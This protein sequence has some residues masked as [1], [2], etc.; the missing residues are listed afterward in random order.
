MCA[1]TYI[2]EHA[3]FIDLALNVD[4]LYVFMSVWNFTCGGN[5]LLSIS[6]HIYM[7]A[8]KRD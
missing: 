2:H 5:R 1:C 6:I 3:I 8:D 4:K 7:A